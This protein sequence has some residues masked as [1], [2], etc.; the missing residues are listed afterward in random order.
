MPKEFSERDSLL[1]QYKTKSGHVV[2]YDPSKSLPPDIVS[3][4]LGY[5][6]A[7]VVN[8]I[9][10]ITR[11]S[12]PPLNVLELGVGTGVC[13]VSLLGKVNEK[14]G[15]SL[16]GIDIDP[17]AVA[18]TRKNIEGVITS[19]PQKPE[20]EITQGD[21]LMEETWKKFG[22]RKYQ[23]IIFNPPYLPSNEKVREGY[24]TVPT[25][26]MY[27]SDE[28]G[29]QHYREVLPHLPSLISDNDGSTILV[30]RPRNDYANRQRDER[31]DEIVDA[32]IKR[33]PG[34]IAS[35]DSVIGFNEERRGHILSITRSKDGT[36]PHRDPAVIMAQRLGLDYVPT[37]D[38]LVQLLS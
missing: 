8:A 30:R 24:E 31:L 5:E 23:V 32:L 15:V 21:W 26:T 14:N 17:Y 6:A 38:E 27:T 34:G 37:V 1:L 4:A 18:L 22:Q 12:N 35:A 19:D 10:F 11:D 7:N 16:H 29:L 3:E 36:A 28:D 9:R 25:L 33:L 20:I 13:L 2:E